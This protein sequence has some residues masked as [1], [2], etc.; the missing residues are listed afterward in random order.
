[1]RMKGEEMLGKIVFGII[2]ASFILGAIKLLL[3]FILAILETANERK[4]RRRK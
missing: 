3:V 1:M 2:L 4:E